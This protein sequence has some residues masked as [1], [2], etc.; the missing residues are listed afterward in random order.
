MALRQG[1][2]DGWG[3]SN[4]LNLLRSIWATL[5]SSAH[6]D[7]VGAGGGDCVAMELVC[8][9]SAVVVS[10]MFPSAMVSSLVAFIDFDPILEHLV[11]R[12]RVD[13]P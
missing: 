11:R 13:K 10:C 9:L 6:N 1:R 8:C 2:I 7:A 12:T 5:S 4:K 3:Q